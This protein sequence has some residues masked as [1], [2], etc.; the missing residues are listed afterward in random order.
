[1]QQLESHVVASVVAAAA[2]AQPSLFGILPV[3]I[4]PPLRN[5]NSSALVSPEHTGSNRLK[6]P[7]LQSFEASLKTRQPL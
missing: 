3:A 5:K 4:A 6:C 1:M 7:C 2:I